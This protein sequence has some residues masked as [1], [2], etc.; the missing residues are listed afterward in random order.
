MLAR[1]DTHVGDIRDIPIQRRTAA[2]IQ[3]VTT[4]QARPVTEYTF[5]HTDLFSTVRYAQRRTA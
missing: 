3:R 4:F 1:S 2:A 5:W